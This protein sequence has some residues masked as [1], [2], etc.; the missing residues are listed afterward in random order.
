MSFF[1]FLITF[2]MDPLGYPTIMTRAYWIKS[3]VTADIW[4]FHNGKFSNK[5]SNLT[6]LDQGERK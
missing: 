3:C 4:P 2:Y 6:D 5:K 1:S